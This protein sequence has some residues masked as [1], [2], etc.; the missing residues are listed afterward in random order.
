M[1]NISPKTPKKKYVSPCT[2]GDIFATPKT[3]DDSDSSLYYSFVV[4]DDEI[5][6]SNKENSNS[7]NEWTVT[8]STPEVSLSTASTSLLR[9][10]LQPSCTPRNKINKRVS[11]KH[12]SIQTNNS[13][14]KTVNSC[15][16]SNEKFNS[17]RTRNID[18]FDESKESALEISQK[19]A[20]N[21]L[22]DTDNFEGEKHNTIIE[23]PLSISPNN[24]HNLNKQ[25]HVQKIDNIN[26]SKHFEQ[27]SDVLKSQVFSDSKVTFGQTTVNQSQL[28]KKTIR[29]SNYTRRSSIYEPRKVNPRKSLEVLKKV[30]NKVSGIGK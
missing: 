9:M 20:D 30:A 25:E 15:N 2:P 23:N 22:S 10:V 21:A 3:I 7:E 18:T 28:R 17:E 26:L 6:S 4:S 14:H 12:L 29:P 24:S 11:F 1:N 13:E 19:D 5:K 16:F 8:S 27:V